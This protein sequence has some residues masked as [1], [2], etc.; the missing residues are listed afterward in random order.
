MKVRLVFLLKFLLL[1]VSQC[2]F[3]S[4]QQLLILAKTQSHLQEASYFCLL[5]NWGRLYK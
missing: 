5:R 3:S 1:V 4:F 2:L